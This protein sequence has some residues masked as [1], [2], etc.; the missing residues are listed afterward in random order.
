MFNNEQLT[1]ITN[2][3]NERLH[4]MDN[5]IELSDELDSEGLQEEKDK[6]HQL[7]ILC[8]NTLKESF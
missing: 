8:D 2:L 4:E 5:L 3:V 7:H 1:L 6:L